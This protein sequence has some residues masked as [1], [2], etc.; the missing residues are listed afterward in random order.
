VTISRPP[1]PD[2]RAEQDRLV[3]VDLAVA[4][5][6]EGVPELMELLTEPSWMIRRS[7]IAGLAA[8]GEAA[9]SGLVD[10]LRHRR[11]DESRIAAA[12]D[13]LA[14][15]NGPA[16]EGA[17][18]LAESDDP[19]VVCGAVQILGRRRAAGAVPVLERLAGGADDNVAV[20]AI[21]ALGRIGGSAALD[22][23]AAA[24]GSGH[25]FRVFPA[26]DALGRTADPRAVAPLAALLE[27]PL[28]ALEAAR[29]LAR[30]GD[31]AA[32]APLSRMLSWKGTANVRTFAL[33]F[34]ELFESAA[35]R[36]GTTRAV[37]HAMSSLP[38]T[39][40]M[41]R[42]L[43]ESLVD[44]EPSEQVALCVVLGAMGDEDSIALLTTL[45]QAPPPVGPAASKA[46]ER[47]GSYAD[48]EIARQLLEGNSAR[49]L[50]VLPLAI[51]SSASDAVARCLSDLEPSVRVLACDVM[52]RI[53]DT[54]RID[55]LFE[56]LFDS[57]ASVVQAAT[58]AIQSLGGDKTESQALALAAS[59]SPAARRA[60]LRLLSYFGYSSA[61]DVFVRSVEDPDRRVQDVAIQGLGLVEH[62]SAA[63]RLIE[64]ARDSS[65]KTRAS[66]MKALGHRPAEPG[67]VDALVDGLRDPDAW[68][69]YY[70]CQS[71]GRSRRA[72]VAQPVAALLDDGAGQVRIAAIEA[73]SVLGGEP[74]SRLLIDAAQS[75][76]ADVSRAALIGLGIAQ[77]EPALPTLMRAARDG[78]PTKR[79]IAIAAISNFRNAEV[80]PLLLAAV[81]DAAETVRTSAIGFLSARP[82]AETSAALIDLL[83]R[84]NAE[85]WALSALSAPAPG[86]ISAI[87]SALRGADEALAGQLVSALARMGT[88][89][90]SSAIVDVMSSPA[91]P[92]RKAAAT[93]LGALGTAAAM[94]TLRRSAKSDPDAD[95]RRIATLLLPG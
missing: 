56:R 28:Y 30:T 36:H 37:A 78:D 94:E 77:L 71:L 13:A 17:L 85:D 41:A 67:T 69:R 45:V 16:T 55:A 75:A 20:A 1:P 31:S 19:A 72:E 5:G 63:Q 48:S 46:L 40:A 83:R 11:D 66:A 47:V 7:V 50:A 64:L 95:V 35:R 52:A 89:E 87:L 4:L 34:A 29:A 68:V 12:V 23:L 10:I 81:D 80:L 53:G 8:L 42:R 14:A 21:E 9:V 33:A 22:S 59:A 65:E 82:G 32:V 76:D 44:A 38:V 88:P 27:Q 26:I 93:T 91:V 18:A 70:A 79:L 15:S 74:S 90:A 62:P 58:A 24:A 60:A 51:R 54:R 39:P 61:F 92:A 49:R 2:S 6:K 25:F 73:L 86:R 3:A 43:R 57:D 84:P